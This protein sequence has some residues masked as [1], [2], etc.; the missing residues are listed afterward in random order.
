MKQAAGF[1]YAVVEGSREHVYALKRL[2]WREAFLRWLASDR[3]LLAVEPTPEP[4][5]AEA[6]F[7]AAFG[8]ARRRALQKDQAA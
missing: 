7:V 8:P 6:G 4:W 3:Q 5:N 2:R 1:T